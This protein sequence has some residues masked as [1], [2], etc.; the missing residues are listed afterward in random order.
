MTFTLDNNSG[1][2]IYAPYFKVKENLH[3]LSKIPTSVFYPP[4]KSNNII[5]IISCPFEENIF[6]MLVEGGDICRYRLEKNT[7]IVEDTYST[8]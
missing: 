6:F 4:P 3:D 2:S 8:E 7:G 1:M 5:E